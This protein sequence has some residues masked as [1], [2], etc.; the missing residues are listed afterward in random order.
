MHE[1]LYDNLI[2]VDDADK[3]DLNENLFDNPEQEV[4][5]DASTVRG[6]ESGGNAEEKLTDSII[7]NNK[8]DAEAAKN[9]LKNLRSDGAENVPRDTPENIREHKPEYEERVIYDNNGVK[10][11]EYTAD[12][13]S[14]VG[15]VPKTSSKDY[16]LDS[17]VIRSGEYAGMTRPE[18]LDLRAI[19]A[20]ENNNDNIIGEPIS[21][22]KEHNKQ[23]MPYSCAIACQRYAIEALTGKEL[24]EGDLREIGKRFGYTDDQGTPFCNSGKVA[25]TFGLKSEYCTDSAGQGLNLE[26]I[27]ERVENGE[28]L[29]VAADTSKLYYPDNI[30]RPFMITQPNH[31]IEIIGFDKT[32]PND[33]KVI[34]NDPGF[35]D[36]AGNVYSWNEFKGCCDGDFVT[37]H[38]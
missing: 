8:S 12:L 29:I 9:I 14:A 25:E 20:I 28:K 13:G 35:E 33:I 27:M 1:N 3:K 24:D 22:M 18:R 10:I 11:T 23:E 21:D 7:N 2:S 38:K 37:I 6:N 31:A 15:D 34:V 17:Y 4:L 32:D 19:D 16:T 26:N 5:L 36:G 30:F